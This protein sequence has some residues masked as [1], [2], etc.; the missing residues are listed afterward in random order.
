MRSPSYSRPR[1]LAKEEATPPRVT[2][3]T[4]GVRQQERQDVEGPCQPALPQPPPPGIPRACGEGEEGAS[5]DDG[6]QAENGGSYLNSSAVFGFR[7]GLHD[8]RTE[9]HRAIQSNV[10]WNALAGGK[11]VLVQR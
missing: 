8:V 2:P 5:T 1:G 3:S 11:R 4:H 7:V 9:V 10:K 6:E